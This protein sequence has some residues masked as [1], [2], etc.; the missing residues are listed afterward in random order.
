MTGTLSLQLQNNCSLPIRFSLQLDSLSSTRAK[1]RQQLPQFLTSRAKRAEVVGE[2]M[3]R[4]WGRGRQRGWGDRTMW[5][6]GGGR[7]GARREGRVCGGVEHRRPAGV[8][9]GG[10]LGSRRCEPGTR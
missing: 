9:G 4:A 8:W 1:A 7:D 3:G 2:L 10:T 6:V 5:G